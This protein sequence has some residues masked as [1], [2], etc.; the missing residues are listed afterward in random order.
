MLLVFSTW[1]HRDLGCFHTTALPASLMS[2]QVCGHLGGAVMFCE[3]LRAPLTSDCLS[4]RKEI[5][6][7]LLEGLIP[8][9]VA[10]AR[11]VLISAR[12]KTGPLVQVEEAIHSGKDQ[13]RA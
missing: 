3:A 1:G 10:R 6:C 8:A 12:N 11:E 7:G 9:D 5:T 2:L 13:L 4:S